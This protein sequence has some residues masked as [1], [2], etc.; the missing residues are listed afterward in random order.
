MQPVSIPMTKKDANDNVTEYRVIP[1]VFEDER[2]KTILRQIGKDLRTRF[3]KL[4]KR[5]PDASSRT[6]AI[7]M[8]SWLAVFAAEQLA[9][10]YVVLVELGQ[11][12]NLAAMNT[13]KIFGDVFEEQTKAMFRNDETKKDD[14]ATG[15]END[16]DIPEDAESASEEAGI[17]SDGDSRDREAGQEGKNVHGGESVDTSGEVSSDA[18][19][20]TEPEHPVDDSSAS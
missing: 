13:L 14:A 15:S 11:E 5:T 7:E 3:M 9:S 4:Y 17:P 8:S 10:W 2:F 6:P 12:P 19:S 20:E 18:R 16:S 1:L